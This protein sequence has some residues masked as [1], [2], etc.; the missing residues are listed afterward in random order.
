MYNHDTTDI[1]FT[2]APLPTHTPKK[3]RTTPHHAHHQ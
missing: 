3:H 2:D 1:P